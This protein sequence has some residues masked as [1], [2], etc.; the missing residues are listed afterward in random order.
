MSLHNLPVEVLNLARRNA[1]ECKYKK[2]REQKEGYDLL[3]V[4][5]KDVK[6]EVLVSLLSIALLSQVY[7]VGH[8]KETIAQGLANL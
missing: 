7:T 8:E 1:S 3:L 5:Q 4:S 2:W 6:G